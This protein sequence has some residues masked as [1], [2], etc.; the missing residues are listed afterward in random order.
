MAAVIKSKHYSQKDFKVY[1]KRRRKNLGLTN[2]TFTYT[3]ST[4]TIRNGPFVSTNGSIVFSIR[5]LIGGVDTYKLYR[6]NFSDLSAV[7]SVVY[8][9]VSSGNARYIDNIY[10]TFCFTNIA[11]NKVCYINMAGAIN[12]IGT[13]TGTA[14][15]GDDD[16]NAP[17]SIKHNSLGQLLIADTGNNRIKT[18]DWGVYKSK[19]TRAGKNIYFI[20]C[21]D[22]GNL[23]IG[24]ETDKTIEKY[25]SAGTLL[26]SWSLAYATGI[27]NYLTG[28]AY[29]NVN[30]KVYVSDYAGSKVHS[31]NNDGTG[32]VDLISGIA[33][34]GIATN[35]TKI[36]VCVN[37]DIKVYDTAGSLIQTVSSVGGSY[38]ISMSANYIYVVDISN[39]ILKRISLTDYTVT[40]L[41]SSLPANTYGVL[42]DTAEYI[43]LTNHTNDNI[44]KYTPA[45]IAV[46]T[47]AAAG[48]GDGQLANA[49]SMAFDSYTGHI[50]IADSGNNRIQKFAFG[51]FIAKNTVSDILH[52]DID[53]TTD[54]IYLTC[55]NDT[56]SYV[57]KKLNSS[58]VEQN[59]YTVTRSSF[60]EG[61]GIILFSK[62]EN[63]I[64]LCDFYPYKYFITRNAD[65]GS[66]PIYFPTLARSG[67]IYGGFLL[68][69]REDVL[70]KYEITPD[71][72]AN[73]IDVTRYLRQDSI[74]IKNTSDDNN[75]SLG[76]VSLADISF[77]F[78]NTEERF[79]F[80]E[81]PESLFYSTG[82][83]YQRN[84]S[85]I[86]ITCEDYEIS[87][88]LI[89]SKNIKMNEGLID[90]KTYTPLKYLETIL[91]NDIYPALSD[92]MTISEILPI[93]INN[94]FFENIIEYDVASIAILNDIAIDDV[95]ALPPKTLDILKLLAQFGGFKFGLYNGYK[96]YTV[97]S[98]TLAAA[99]TPDYIITGNNLL[100]V[101]EYNNGE[102][103]LF[104]SVTMKYSAG[105]A[106]FTISEGAQVCF[107]EDRQINIESDS[108]T[109][110]AT[111]QAI[112]DV[113]E[114]FTSWPSKEFTIKVPFLNYGNNLFNK[115]FVF[116]IF[117]D[118]RG[119][120]FN[121]PS[122]IGGGAYAPDKATATDSASRIIYYVMGVEHTI[123]KQ[124]FT[125]LKLKE[126]ITDKT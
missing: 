3:D 80:E 19:I 66:K 20:A 92:G 47:F 6:N 12:Y 82:K 15:S 94:R 13:S 107:N 74:K 124:N 36:A 21:E 53:I 8:T 64:Y 10:D 122:L 43:Y 115:I 52:F 38:A 125:I 42:V 91:S 27:A 9:G 86:R 31:Y 78:D 22:N 25:N 32:H 51:K 72:D 44:T 103:R 37:G 112:V 109:S 57:V 28:L 110:A 2:R 70:N 100:G 60:Y 24:N 67:N 23:Y 33:A 7:D 48:T 102:H 35:G 56:T 17:T 121:T 114:N 55:N 77:T 104:K 68:A 117:S 81:N 87:R 26:T 49:W 65:D 50:Y 59:S 123:G 16:W 101:E 69:G 90:I 14:G 58:F 120:K 41:I 108:I 105:T 93:V 111:A 11:S 54:D 85:I 97:D 45:G 76:K 34:T 46:S 1:L 62:T 18:Y 95:A 30:N 88:T 29:D 61:F 75:F 118:L 98:V 73:W 40:N 63:K 96:F 89:D 39:N 4:A 84:Q 83:I 113:F 99:A 119:V 79:D 116:N 126:F 106:T 5:I 71:Y